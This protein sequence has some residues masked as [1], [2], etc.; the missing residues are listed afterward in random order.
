MQQNNSSIIWKNARTVF[1]TNQLALLLGETNTTLV[2]KR[3]YYFVH[4]GQL[5]SLQRG[6]YAKP[7]YNPEELAC[8][9]QVPCYLSLEYVLQKAG[10]VFQYDSTLTAVSFR[11][12]L[13]EVGGHAIQYRQMRGELLADMRG[14]RNIGNIN[15][16]TPE[17]AF[18]DTL[19]LNAQYHFDNLHS[20]DRNVV[21]DL[22]PLYQSERMTERVKAMFNA[23]S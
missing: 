19:Y 16:A 18:L 22:L 23:K 10:I 12:R 21:Q 5:L 15:I 20:L 9:L 1:T 13:L 6:V 4:S 2:A 14:I 3:M 7:G 11:N 8:V 17:R